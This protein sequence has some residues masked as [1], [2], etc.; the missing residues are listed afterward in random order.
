MC[1]HLR[2]DH[3]GWNIRL[4]DGR[5]V[6]TFPNARYLFSRREYEHWSPAGENAEGYGQEGV[7]ADSVLPCA[8][9]AWSP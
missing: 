8:E 9:A 5:W 3:V 4:Q 1:T 7:F 6:P 2:A